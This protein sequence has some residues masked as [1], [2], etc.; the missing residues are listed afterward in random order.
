MAGGRLV[1]SGQVIRPGWKENG[2]GIVIL[3][4]FM[5]INM[6]HDELTGY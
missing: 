4:V 2:L 5:A 6:N 3:L 1:K